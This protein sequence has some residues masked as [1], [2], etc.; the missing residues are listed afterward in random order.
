MSRISRRTVLRGAVAGASF[1]ATQPVWGGAPAAPPAPEAPPPETPIEPWVA[2]LINL[3]RDAEGR[4]HIERAAFITPTAHCSGTLPVAEAAALLKDLAQHDFTAFQ[5][6]GLRIAGQSFVLIRRDE[7]GT[8]P[9]AYAVRRGEFV[10]VRAF[11][12]RADLL[13]Q[14]RLVIA[15]SGDGMVHGRAAE[16]VYQFVLKPR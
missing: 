3:S 9:F 11:R 16:A 14:R 8:F 12:L 7:E 1:L 2:E 15:T 4:A 13:S 5:E 6:R 10:T